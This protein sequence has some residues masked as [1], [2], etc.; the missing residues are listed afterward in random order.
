MS[1]EV[2]KLV[3]IPSVLKDI[4]TAMNCLEKGH[5]FTSVNDTKMNDRYAVAIR[6]LGRHVLELVESMYAPEEREF[7]CDVTTT[8]VT[9]S[10]KVVV[11]KDA[12]E[13]KRKVIDQ[14]VAEDGANPDITYEVT[15]TKEA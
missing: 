15:R 4:E 6:S 8:D 12:D 1:R 14:M 3:G 5:E 13:A 10:Q 7:V 2:K 9:Y 11:A